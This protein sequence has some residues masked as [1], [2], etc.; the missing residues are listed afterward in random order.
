MGDSTKA[1]EAQLKPMK[2]K[3][4]D[5]EYAAVRSQIRMDEMISVNNVHIMHWAISFSPRLYRSCG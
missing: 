4:W 2:K 1:R 3:N 5:I